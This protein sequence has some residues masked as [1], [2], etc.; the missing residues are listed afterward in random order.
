[1][2]HD[3]QEKYD[4]FKRYRNGFVPYDQFLDYKKELKRKIETAKSNYYLYKFEHCRNDS[5]STWKLTN[6]I[7]GRKN[8]SKIPASLMHDSDEI[9]DEKKICNIFNQYFVNIGSNL[10]ST[11][12][13][14]D[15]NP[16][17]NLGD[18]HQNSFSF[19]ATTPKEVFNT[20]KKFDNKKSSL[21]NVPIVILKKISHIISPLLSDIFNHSINDGIFPEKLKSGRVT[22]IYKEG[23]LN[24]VSN[25]RPI[26]SLSVFFQI[27]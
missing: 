16:I 1:M 15:L 21:N 5:S 2:L 25:Y 23:D 18:R 4:I 11:I 27:I 12:H 14:N 19:M 13:T 20:I 24:D 8:K 6:N 26:T 17:Y 10:A 9:T 7:L 22:P 3:I